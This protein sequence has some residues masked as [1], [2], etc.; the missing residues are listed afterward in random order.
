MRTRR[1][2]VES[3]STLHIYFSFQLDDINNYFNRITTSVKKTAINLNPVLRW[4]KTVFSSLQHLHFDESKQ[5]SL[6]V[7]DTI[8]VSNKS[9]VIDQQ[10][11]VIP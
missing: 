4:L 3:T 1:Y 6:S 7:D 11:T 2:V 9:A 5:Q 8:M 10:V